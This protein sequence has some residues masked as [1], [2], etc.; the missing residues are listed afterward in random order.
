MKHIGVPLTAG[1]VLLVAST[2]GQQSAQ[3]ATTANTDTTFTITAGTLDIT[4]PATA[5]IGAPTG[6]APGTTIANTIG[7]TTRV[8]VVDGRGGPAGST[9]TATVASTVFTRATGT[10]TLP[11]TA[12]RYASG[13]L[14]TTPDA[15]IGT[16]FT[17]GQATATEPAALALGGGTPL[18]AFSWGGS[19][20]NRASWDPLVAVDIPN[21][22]VA[23]TY[24]GTIT[25]SVSGT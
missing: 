14:V 11:A 4:A 19:G 9:W 2:L 13:P 23:G 22:A 18:T 25:H 24:N 1:V 3:A 16:G 5:T 17:P 10:Q 20:A 6:G 21:T 8:Q 7:D 15:T 12:V